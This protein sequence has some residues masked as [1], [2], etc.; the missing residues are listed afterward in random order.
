MALERE[1]ALSATFIHSPDYG[2]RSSAIVR[3]EPGKLWMAER[4]YDH[5][6]LVGVAQFTV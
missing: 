2:T 1:R 3:M 5:S 6:G 4:S